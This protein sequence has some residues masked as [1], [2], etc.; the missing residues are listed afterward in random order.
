V[1]GPVR[2]GLL[3]PSSNTVMET[4]FH[5]RL[6]ADRFSVHTGRMFLEETTPEAES[7]MLDYHVMPAARD[8][9]TARPDVLVFGCT[10]AGAL[11]GNEA[12]R[13]LCA[14]MAEETGT[15]VI[16]TI[17]SVRA[18]LTRR[19]AGRIAVITPYVD[20]LNDKIRE[21]IEADGIEV[22]AIDGLGITENFAIA[23]VEPDE[24]VAFARRT[25]QGLAVDLVF[26]SCTNFRAVDALPAI[27]DA[28]GV[29]AVSSNQAVLEA[30]LERFGMSWPADAAGV[31]PVR[32]GAGGAGA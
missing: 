3:V 12:D 5:R 9:A 23:E 24:I 22:A 13:E 4:D 21:S 29:P 28:L 7:D 30:V 19:R 25:V 2:V 26:A 17:A 11:R 8:V 18:A 6:P 16:S 1:T 20:A 15:E 14:R 27:E 10:S 32:M 31:D